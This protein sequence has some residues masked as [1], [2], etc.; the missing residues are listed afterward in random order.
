MSADLVISGGTVIDGTGS[1]GRAAD[2]A[3]T[4][5]RVTAIGANLSGRRHLDAVGQ[6]VSPGFIDIHTHYDAQVFWDPD[7]TPSSFHGVT[8]VVAGNCGL[9]IAPTRESD[10]RSMVRILENVEDM[11]GDSL[12]AGVPW[13]FETFPDYLAAVRRRGTLL[14]YAVFVGHT[15]LRLYVMGEEAFERIST[16]EER[17]R[18]CA[19][20]KEAMLAGG[21]GLSTSFAPTHRDADGRAIPSRLSDQAEFAQLCGV[22]GDVGLGVVEVSPGPQFTIDDLYRLQPAARAPFTYGALLSDPSGRHEHL[23]RQNRDGWAAGAR[24][25]PQVTPLPVQVEFSMAEPG[26]LLSMNPA[27]QP[28][29]GR[30]LEVRRAA[31]TDPEWRAQAVHGFT[32]QERLRPRWDTYEIA[33]SAAHPE[34]AGRRVADLA[35]ERGS[36][37]LD[38]ILDLALESADLDVRVHCIVSNDDSDSV[39]GLLQEEHC[40][41]GLSDAGAHVNQLCDASQ[42]TSFLG[43]WVRDRSLMPMEDAIRKLTGVQADLFGFA[44]RGYLRPGGWAD[45]VVFDPATVGSGPVRRVRDFPAEGDRLTADRPTGVIHVV[46]NGVPI[47]Q[48]GEMLPLGQG[49]RPGQVVGP[50]RRG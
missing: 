24:V 4:D 46:V 7:L 34:L 2:V 22:L 31:Y 50:T 5:G 1:P 9:S 15:P 30:P 18:M 37:P 47:R 29:M 44:D 21:A 49:D 40:T 25:W 13:D 3:I 6:I 26:V 16:A 35:A 11:N 32:V 41:F 20:L 45:V 19:V 39:A 38:V 43:A 27:F 10:R 33:A 36:E 48:D 12:A 17:D 23:V 28:L 14:N 8:T 42:A